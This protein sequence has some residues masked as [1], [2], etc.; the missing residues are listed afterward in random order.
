MWQMLKAAEKPIL[1][2]GM[3][4][5]AEKILA[6][7][8]SRKIPVAGIFASDGFV[9][10]HSFAGYEVLAYS[11]AK[12]RFG[13]MIVLLCFGSHRPDVVEYVKGIAAEQEFYAPDVPVFGGGLFT[14][15]YAAAHRTELE[16]VYARLADEE[17]RL[18]FRNV[19]EYKLTGRME[20]LFQCETPAAEGWQLLAPTGE[21]IYLDLGAY[22]GDTVREFIEAAGGEYRRIYAVEPDPKTFRKLQKNTEGLHDCLLYNVGIHSDYARMTFAED[23][24]RGSAVAGQGRV[25]EMDSVDHLLAGQPVTVIKMDVE[26]EE[27][28]ALRGMVKTLQNYRPRLLVSAYHRTEDLFALPLQ[29]LA[30]RPDYKVYLRH[31]PCLPAWDVN[32]YFV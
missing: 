8:N 17:S 5:G 15:E 18:V 21:D 22:N 26:G 3:G 4:N 10:G 19:I 28:E 7:L 13:D 31:H 25:T 14:R 29:V 27:A 30:I 1:L 23:A 24:G 16:E 9:R 12:R 2:Y 32:Y 11:E 6:E 20:P